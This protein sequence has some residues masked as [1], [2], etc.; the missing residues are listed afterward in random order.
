MKSVTCKIV[1]LLA[2]SAAV[3]AQNSIEHI[4]FIVKENHSFDNLFGQF[5]G[6]DGASY[7]YCGKHQVRLSKPPKGR[8]TDLPHNWFPS[9]TAINGGKMDRFCKVRPNTPFL[10]YMQYGKRNL[11]NYWT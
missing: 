6:A 2:S 5:P 7:G 4:V 10:P 3:R 9:H 11:P 1:M 8:L